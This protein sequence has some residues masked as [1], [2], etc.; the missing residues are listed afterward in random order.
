MD[1]G[2]ERSSEPVRVEATDGP[3]RG[4]IAQLGPAGL[5][6]GSDPSCDLML[7][8]RAVSRRH[9]R[10]E[11]LPGA[12]HARDLGSRNGTSYL[13]ARIMEALVPI[14]GTLRVGKTTLRFHRA[15]SPTAP[16]EREELCGLLGRSPA[17]RRLFAT[18]EK[19]G[20]SEST[21]LVRGETGVG[22][23][24]VA[25]VLH[26]LSPRAA[27]PL[28][29]FDCAAFTH[30]LVESELF[31]HVK[32]AFTGAESDRAGTVAHA[33]G[34]TLLLDNAGELPLDLQ[35]KLLRLLEAREYRPVGAALP[36]AASIR[37]IATT[38]R[39]LE[40][41]AEAGRF[42]RDLYYRLAVAVVDV[43]ALRERK[44]DIPLLTA[45]FARGLPGSEGRLTPTIR[46]MLQCE[47]WPGNVRELRNAV[48]RAMALGEPR[49]A[50]PSASAE[51]E[52]SLKQS[53]ALL[54]ETFEHDYLVELLAKHDGNI[55]AAARDAKVTRMTLYR[56]LARCGLKS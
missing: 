36:K 20:P 37:V 24:A 55:A 23:D 1:F 42:R 53:R 18:L 38:S 12:V 19:L 8:D 16:S 5:L 17:M 3:G 31:G 26:A 14:G 40:A 27:S 30:S 15:S 2:P 45:H 21:V 4:S 29:V 54:L 33:E 35:P 13:G 7:A 9:L 44:E 51:S 46:A 56:M 52:G 50:R 49:I 32:G 48:E 28:V 34:G 10:L 6:V 39:D 22:K 25:R 47:A 11:L 41:E 43:P